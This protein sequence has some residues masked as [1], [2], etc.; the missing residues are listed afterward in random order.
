MTSAT[1]AD[2]LLLTLS[3]MA[4]LSLLSLIGEGLRARV[5]PGRHDPRVETFITRV[6]SWWGMVVL[7]ALALLA[8]RTGV[9]LLFAFAAFAALREFITYSSKAR[10]DHIALALAFF[11]VLP[12]QFVLVGAALPGLF[13]IFVPVYAFLLLPVV[14]VLRND[15]HRFLMRVAE[16]QWGLMICVYCISH[17]P[18]LL[19]LDLPM[20]AGRAVLLIAFLIV[21]VQV[22]DLMDF[23]LGRAFGRH[24]I[25]PALSAKTWEGAAL[26]IGCAAALGGAIHWITPFGPAG[27]I[28][29]AAVASATG[30]CGNLVL[31]AIKRDRGLRDWSH[32]IPGH[33]G[34]LDQLDSVIFAAPIF[35]HLTRSFWA[36]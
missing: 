5:G 11:V 33:G 8:G 36:L 9:L 31:S 20:E 15:A 18:A 14:S 32:L 35:Y 13:G 6:H 7:F 29:M 10:G 23:I 27:A 17:V 1:F 2:I 4:V 16:T 3:A 34:L 21:V 30:M 22:G 25:A 24:R 26:G 12:V 19:T 28:A